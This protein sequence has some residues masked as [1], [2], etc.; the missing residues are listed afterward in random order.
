MGHFRISRPSR[1]RLSW[2]VII[3]LMAVVVN[4]ACSKVRVVPPNAP[5]PPV[6]R[7]EQALE[8]PLS[9]GLVTDGT[10]LFTA[11]NDGSLIGKEPAHGETRWTRAG[12]QPRLL[13]ARPGMLVV[14]EKGG[15]LWGIRTEDGTAAWKVTT[16]VSD[17]QSIRLD[18]NRVF[19]G[20]SQ[21]L[22][23]LIVTTG[24]LRYDLPAKAVTDIDAAGEFLA[25][26]EE[27]TLVQRDRETG[28]VRFRVVSPEGQ[29]GAPAVFDDGNVILGSGSRLVR[30]VSK[31]GG[32]GWRFKVGASVEHR[33]LDF[34]DTKRVGVV[35]FEGVFYELSKGG[36]DM[37]R[38]VLLSS[39]PFAMPTLVAGRIW[40]P[41]FEDEVS[42]IDAKTTKLIGRARFGGSFVAPPV[43]VGP[44]LIGEV[45]GPRRL[46][47]LQT[48]AP[49]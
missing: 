24:E 14:A 36:G 46:V 17:V 32:W 21:G 25:S 41:I 9:V 45:T 13:A 19:V 16:Q 3:G 5:F 30:E 44:W 33:P 27:G 31:S 1:F 48:A 37:R 43:L 12:M 49:Q 28:A 6:S 34:Q 22:A 47:A 42:V 18:G 38:R 7:W 26:L 20:G 10:L 23:A 35:S 4:A 29:F 11:L 8:T 40:A 15:T 2:L 39:R